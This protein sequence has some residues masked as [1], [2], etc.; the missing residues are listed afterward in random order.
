MHLSRVMKA[1]DQVTSGEKQMHEWRLDPAFTCPGGSINVGVSFPNQGSLP[2]DKIPRRCIRHTTVPHL[3]LIIDAQVV[4][5]ASDGDRGSVGTRRRDLPARPVEHGYHLEGVEEDGWL[6]GGGARD[7]FRGL[8]GCVAAGSEA[9]HS[10]GC[11]KEGAEGG[12]GGQ[13]HE[14]W[15]N[16]RCPHGSGSRSRS[17]GHACRGLKGV[18]VF[19]HWRRSDERSYV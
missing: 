14:S 15:E 19:L 5:S 10:L 9:P 18:V 8:Q 1:C 16:F 4:P 2:E 11:R 12:S 17:H 3:R 13:E 6:P 7:D